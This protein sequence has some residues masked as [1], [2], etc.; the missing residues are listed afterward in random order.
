MPKLATE[1]GAA[2]SRRLAHW[3]VGA[4]VVTPFAVL[5]LWLGLRTAS[6]DAQRLDCLAQG[7]SVQVR[8]GLLRQGGPH[9]YLVESGHWSLITQGCRGEYRAQCLDDNPGV[10]ALEH[11]LGQRVDVEYCDAHVVGYTV[12]GQR[13][14]HGQPVSATQ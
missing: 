11:H 9:L 3:V 2:P 13:F 7:G 4:M 1:H 12:S 10:G 14:R 6:T 5:M 8:Q